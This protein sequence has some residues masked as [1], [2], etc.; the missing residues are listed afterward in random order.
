MPQACALPQ[1]DVVAYSSA[2]FSTRPADSA[3]LD[4]SDDE[5]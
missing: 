4:I 3:R 2:L 1:Y 5:R